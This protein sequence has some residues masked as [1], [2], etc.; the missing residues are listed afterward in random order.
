LNKYKTINQSV[1]SKITPSDDYK[2]K[3]DTTLQKIKKKIKDE[4]Q[5]RNIPAT[6]ELVGS[7]AKDTYLRDN[8]DMDI[9]LVFPRTVEKKIIA[10]ETLSLGK[11]I[12]LETEECYAEHPYIRGIYEGFKVELVPCY[13]IINAADRITA[14][15]RTPL[16]TQ[17]VISHLKE[18]QKQEVGFSNNFFMALAAMV[19]KQISKDFLDISVNFL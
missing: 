9:F 14:V 10:Q 16:H 17:Y 8:L 3:V 15:D 4:I 7:I 13:H 5:K 19:Q 11:T 18:N 2:K 12:L 6:I 1:L